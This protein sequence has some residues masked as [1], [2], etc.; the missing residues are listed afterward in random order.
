MHRDGVVVAGRDLIADRLEGTP[1]CS[2]LE[3]ATAYKAKYGTLRFSPFLRMDC[4]GT[5]N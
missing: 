4:P 5:K 3:S 2:A 1:Q